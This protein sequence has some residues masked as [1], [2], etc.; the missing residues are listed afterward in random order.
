MAIDPNKGCLA[1][2]R[3]TPAHP[4]S[5]GILIISN[6]C[7][8]LRADRTPPLPE[9]GQISSSLPP[10]FASSMPDTPLAHISMAAQSR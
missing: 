5:V 4:D 3:R 8:P 2:F 7:G 9:R 6:R 10:T 1:D